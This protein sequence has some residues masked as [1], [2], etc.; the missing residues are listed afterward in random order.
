M[1]CEQAQSLLMDYLYDEI[2]DEDRLLF[3]A[4]LSQCESCQQELESLRQTSTLLQ[5]WEDV[6]PDFNVVMVTEKVSWLGRLVQGIGNYLPKPRKI[7]AGVAIAVAGLFLLLAIANT[8]ISYRQGEFK[9]SLGLFSKP[10]DRGTTVSTVDPQWV[11]QLQKQNY[12]LM[13][14]LIQQSEQ[15]QRK[16]LASAVLQ[17]RQEL[18][19]Q[20]IEDLNLV[21]FGLDDI[22]QTTYRQIRRTDE[23]LNQLM[24]FI[25]ARKQLR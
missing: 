16:E 24:K 15:R 7:A 19:R 3:Q 6:T 2:S 12:Y 11:E 13:N 9:M 18:E 22:K 17:L 25:N 20:R 4:H 5:Q 23:S 8:E 10:A 14:S 1:N 21:G